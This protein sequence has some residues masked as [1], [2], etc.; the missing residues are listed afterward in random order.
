MG[1]VVFRKKNVLSAAVKIQTMIL[2][3]ALSNA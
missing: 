1:I 2:T 3:A